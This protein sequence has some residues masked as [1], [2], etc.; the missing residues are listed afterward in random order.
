M[1]FL[2]SWLKY[3]A[4]INR[5]ICAPLHCVFT[6]ND[7]RKLTGHHRPDV[8]TELSSIIQ[9]TFTNGASKVGVLTQ[10]SSARLFPHRKRPLIMTLRLVGTKKVS[11]LWLVGLSIDWGMSLITWF[12]FNE[13]PMFFLLLNFICNQ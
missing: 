10:M 13:D 1:T 7:L 2:Q 4:N 5:K 3:S 12:R 6:S 9:S 11:N 8:V